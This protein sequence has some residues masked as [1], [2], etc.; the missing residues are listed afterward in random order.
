M[1][2][3]IVSRVPPAT[4]GIAEYNAMLG[5]SLSSNGVDVIFV[6]NVEEKERLPATYVEPYSGLRARK[7]FS[8][9]KFRA[10]DVVDCVLEEDPDIVHVEHDY[11]IFRDSGE[12]ETMLREI[13]KRGYPVA[14]TLHSV[15]H[16][17]S[18]REWV[19]AQVKM[20][21][22]AD[23]IIVHSVLQL[24]ELQY[25]GVDISKIRV[26]PHGTLLNPF[27]GRV[28]RSS[29]ISELAGVEADLEGK[30]VITVPGFSR[31]NKGIDIVLEVFKAVRD[32]TESV[33][34]IG[35]PQ[36]PRDKALVDKLL[37]EK[38][39]IVIPKFINRTEFL[40]LLASV[41]VA[42]FPYRQPRVIAVSGAFH[43][44]IGSKLRLVCTRHPKLFECEMLAPNVV[45]P[46]LKPRLLAPL[47]EKVASKNYD[48]SR[49]LDRLW[50]YAEETSWDRVARKT[51]EV[52]K[53]IVS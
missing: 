8:V 44:A 26:V 37:D 14:I 27:L 29:V 46:D 15:H 33:L 3:A 48:P 21:N 16:A 5:E 34:V 25:Q 19:S 49:D 53:E 1:R 51:I 9:D 20:T 39:V 42:V 41:D 36:R 31:W 40:R 23:A 17:L 30:T 38:G 52:Y 4:C 11:D 10:G 7:C 6:G 35:V 47:L 13:K 24:H 32:K 2:V 18:G 43:L 45:A 12:T 28:D 50:K 22:I